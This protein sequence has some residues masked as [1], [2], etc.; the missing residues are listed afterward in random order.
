MCI[1]HKTVK[2]P[3]YFTNMREPINALPLMHESALSHNLIIIGF[4]VANDDD[5]TVGTKL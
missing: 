5:G 4:C 3:Q 1:R 2:E